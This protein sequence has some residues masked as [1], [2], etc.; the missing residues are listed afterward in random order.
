MKNL[1]DINVSTQE[2][3]LLFAALSILTVSPELRILGTTV[4]G[5]ATSL[6]EMIAHIEAVTDSIHFESEPENVFTV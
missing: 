5:N 6:D 4:K 2:G 1:S 3:K